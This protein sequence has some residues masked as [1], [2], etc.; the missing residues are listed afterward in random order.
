[1]DPAWLAGS[2]WSLRDALGTGG[3]RM[4]PIR[5]WGS[6]LGHNRKVTGAS[7]SILLSLEIR[8]MCGTD[9]S[10]LVVGA[11]LSS[12]PWDVFVNSPQMSPGRAIYL[13]DAKSRHTAESVLQL[14]F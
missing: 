7:C 6:R 3:I 2:G 13:T 11:E 9:P 8:G 1:V 4:C 10:I 5:P 12:G 14:E